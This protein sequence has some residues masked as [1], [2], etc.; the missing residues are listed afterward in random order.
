MVH[1]AEV[2]E[3]AEVGAARIPGIVTPD[4]QA[5]VVAAPMVTGMLESVDDLQ[6]AV[7]IGQLRSRPG[8]A[9]CPRLELSQHPVDDDLPGAQA[10]KPTELVDVV[11]AHVGC[12]IRGLGDEVLLERAPGSDVRVRFDHGGPGRAR[13]AVTAPLPVGACDPRAIVPALVEIDAHEQTFL[14]GEVADP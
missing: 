5:L 12:W 6:D 8:I 3:V 10:G 1:A 9:T 4:L 14:P 2:I 11:T 13:N 7:V